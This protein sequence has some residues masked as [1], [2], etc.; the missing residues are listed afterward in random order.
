MMPTEAP[1]LVVPGTPF[2]FALVFIAAVGA[3]AYTASRRFQL[4]THGGPPDV[5]WDDVGSRLA[6][7][8]EFGLLQRK[9][10]RDAYAGLYHILI[11]S[12]FVVLSVRTVSLVFEG[13][14]TRAS[15]PFLPEGLWHGYLFLKDI[16]LVTTFVGVVLALGRRYVVKKERLDPSF[17]AGFILCLIG[18][19]MVSDLL[20]GAAKFNLDP[21]A[22]RWEP[23]TAALATLLT[24]SSPGTLKTVFAVSWW[25]HLV[26]VFGF[27]NYL[28]FAK[29][30]HVITALPNIFLRKLD[31][32]GKL[33]TFDVE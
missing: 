26:A 23:A 17:D 21:H 24:G 25:A 12:G 19:L 6:G 15:L 27:L 13:L 28:P 20:A 18:F 9:M 32:P 1:Q 3:F 33:R 14:T 16:V 11:F 10:F 31:A 8:V 2:L 29:H 30:F 7:L 4:M 22:S 5:R